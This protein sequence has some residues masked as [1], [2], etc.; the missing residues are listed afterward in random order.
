[1]DGRFSRR[2]DRARD[3]RHHADRRPGIGSTTPTAGA[4]VDGIA[5]ICHVP[6]NGGVRVATLEGVSLRGRIED[7]Q[8]GFTSDGRI[9]RPIRA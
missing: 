1:L 8:V 2:Y 5:A 6:D 7:G 3:R 4:D 9:A